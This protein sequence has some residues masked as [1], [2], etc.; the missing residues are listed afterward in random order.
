MSATHL[1]LREPVTLPVEA[2]AIS[3]DRFAGLAEEEVAALPVLRGRRWLRLDDLFQ[4]HGAGSEQITVEGD[5]Q[6]VKRIGQGMSRGRITVH[7]DAGM[8]LGAGMIGGEIEVHG[9]VAAWAGVEM[10]G[11]HLRVHGDAGPQLGGVYPG[12]ARGMRGGSILVD[13]DAGPRAGERMRRGLIAIG[14]SA[15]EFAGARLIAGSILV[16]GRLGP[17]PGAGMK[18]GTIVALGGLAEGLLPTFAYDC[19]YRPDFLRLY[20]GWLQGRGF[21]VQAAQMEGFYRRYSGDINTVGKGEI[22]VYDQP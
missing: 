13:G 19:T 4:V 5:L 8:H 12:E 7:G 10:E 2:E 17:R 1:R 9:D 14:G 3:P 20:L 18:R 11:G 6:H 16:R 21:P 15:G 22:L